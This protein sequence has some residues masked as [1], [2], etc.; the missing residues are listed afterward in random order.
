[1]ARLNHKTG[2]SKDML[3]NQLW[4]QEQ[5]L[6]FINLRRVDVGACCGFSCRHIGY[7]HGMNRYQ[8]TAWHHM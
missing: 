2:Y 8:T 6:L 7:L 3:V 1:M 5:N 4:L